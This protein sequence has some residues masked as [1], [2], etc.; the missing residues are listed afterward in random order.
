MSKKK[1]YVYLAGSIS[2]DPETY[3]WRERFIK[4][5]EGYNLEVFNPCANKFSQAMRTVG[6][7]DLN[8]IQEAKKR[9]HYILRAKDYQMVKVCSVVVANLSIA[10][11]KKPMIGTMME[12]AWARDIFYVPVIAIIGDT[13]NPYTSHPW[14]DECCS[15]K[16]TTVEDAI[17]TLE[18]FFLDY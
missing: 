4:G 18:T 17:D 7:S 15:A 6:G 13:P 9:S 3:D 1:H 8:H 10:A 16:V 11:E 14:V 5:T 12:L 2:S